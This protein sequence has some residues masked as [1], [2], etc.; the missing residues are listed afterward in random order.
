HGARRAVHRDRPALR[1]RRRIFGALAWSPR[2][3]L[4]VAAR[5]TPRSTRLSG[6]VGR[7]PPARRPGAGPH[8]RT[9]DPPLPISP[10]RR[11]GAR[12]RT[13]ATQ[14]TRYPLTDRRSGCPDPPC[15][16]RARPRRAVVQRRCAVA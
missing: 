10:A 1:I 5:A 12:A 4:S 3:P 14:W 15:V 2:V 8:A 13:L 6:P 11:V 16:S 7:P 9:G